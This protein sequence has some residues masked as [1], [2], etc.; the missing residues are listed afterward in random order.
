MKGGLDVLYAE[1]LLEVS[2]NRLVDDL[3]ACGWDEIEVEA[4]ADAVLYGDM[5]LDYR[6]TD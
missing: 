3:R 1:T 2:I 5:V 4:I 6:T